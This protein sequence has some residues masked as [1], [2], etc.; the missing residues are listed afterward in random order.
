MK[1]YTWLFKIYGTNQTFDGHNIE[2]KFVLGFWR[3]R[4]ERGD[5]NMN[6][7]STGSEVRRPVCSR[8]LGAVI[9]GAELPATS[10]PRQKLRW[11]H[12]GPRRH[13]PWR[14]DVIPR[15]HDAWRRPPGSISAFKFSKGPIVNF[16]QK[17]TKL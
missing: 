3:E 5:E 15:R 7:A 9:C 14:R 12:P 11:P 16:F 8:E 13:D 17:K 1:E 2:F 6:N 10:D 4:A